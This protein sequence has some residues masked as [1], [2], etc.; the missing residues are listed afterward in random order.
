M[1]LLKSTA[2]S[3][4]CL[5]P[6]D[7]APDFTLNSVLDNK[8]EQVKATLM[9]TFIL[10]HFSFFAIS[11]AL[12]QVSLSSLRG[13]HVLLMFYPV[14][15]GY[16]TPTEFYSLAPLLPLLADF[17]CSVLAISTEHISS[18]R[19]SQAAPRLSSSLISYDKGFSKSKISP[20]LRLDWTAWA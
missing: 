11:D 16:V 20:G 12:N 2:S 5:L 6:G 3:A 1:S 4:S 19:N 14:D 13:Q 15:F 7:R 10:E 18:Q 9:K 17:N 8:E